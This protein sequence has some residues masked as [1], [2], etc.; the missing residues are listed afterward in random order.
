MTVLYTDKETNINHALNAIL[1]DT[2]LQLLIK[3]GD[4]KVEKLNAAIAE[5]MNIN[6]DKD[7]NPSQLSLMMSAYLLQCRYRELT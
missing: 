2:S 6:Q 1:L 4:L 3:N 5:A 7:N